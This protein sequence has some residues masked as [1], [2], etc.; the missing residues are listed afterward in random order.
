MTIR[1]NAQDEEKIKKIGDLSKGFLNLAIANEMLG[2]TTRN[3]LTPFGD[4]IK[5]LKEKKYR[6]VIQMETKSRY[7]VIADLEE[8]KRDL[9]LEGIAFDDRLKL[10]EKELR[11]LKRRVEDKEEEIKEYKE[12]I[13]QQKETNKELIKSV[14]DSLKRFENL[15]QKEKK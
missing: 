11:D 1:F 9:I 8:K 3:W 6:E 13:K 5:K 15:Q 7:E 4:E 12:S 2:N 10:K 14:D